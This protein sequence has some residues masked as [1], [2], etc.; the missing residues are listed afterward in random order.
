M[1]QVKIPV[2]IR[3][4]AISKLLK[5]NS[6]ELE[7]R[8]GIE[9]RS[10]LSQTPPK[11]FG[12]RGFSNCCNGKDFSRHGGLNQAN[13]FEPLPTNP[14]GFQHFWCPFWCPLCLALDQHGIAAFDRDH[15][16]PPKAVEH[17]FAFLVPSRTRQTEPPR[18]G[19]SPSLRVISSV[20]RR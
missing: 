18:A 8:V 6:L 14:C 7:A 1:K 13:N 10:E 16:L 19:T 4:P 15:W 5:I 11:P 12:S 20:L 2:K 3:P 17:D 9:P